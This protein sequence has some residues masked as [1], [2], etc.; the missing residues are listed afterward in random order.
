M[1]QNCKFEVKYGK[2]KL[3]ENYNIRYT[4]ELCDVNIL[5]TRVCGVTIE[6]KANVYKTHVERKCIVK[7]VGVTKAA[8]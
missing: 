6:V 1:Y 2:K 7:L 4:K 5:E 8:F 3:Q